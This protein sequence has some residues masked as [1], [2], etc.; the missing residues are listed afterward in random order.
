MLYVRSVVIF[1]ILSSFTFHTKAI[2][3]FT[4]TY[5]E[6]LA[7]SSK[8]KLPVL[9]YFTAKWCGPCRY[10]DK[11]IFPNDAVHQYV[12][13]NYIALS[14]DVD[15]SENLALYS[16][17]IQSNDVSVPI[18]LI[19]NDKE[20]V[21]KKNEG[22]MKLNELIAFLRIETINEPMYVARPDSIIQK[23]QADVRPPI[24][25]KFFYNSFHNSW[26]LG[27]RFS[28]A[29]SRLAGDDD[30]HSYRRAIVGF[31]V[32]VF[33]ERDFDRFLIQPGIAYARKGGT[34]HRSDE[35]MS[36]SYLEIPINVGIDLFS[37]SIAGTG[38]PIRLNATPYYALLLGGRVGEKGNKKNVDIGNG[39]NQVSTFDYGV[40]TGL[41]M[42]LG[43]FEPAIG[44][45][46]GFNKISKRTYNSSFYFSMS[47]VFGK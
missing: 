18:F 25:E 7:K 28:V 47:V 40:K 45:D 20:E 9:L 31:N 41:S 37:M 15:L 17:Y 19:V 4:G 22:S 35:S 14:L 26:K 8:E 33:F 34:N 29:S 10:M 6:A 11:Y 24:M 27:V 12:A 13:T 16:K 5:K 44:Y 1:I 21:L 38:R 3:F 46:W 2:D 23:E 36:L 42:G 43:S 30:N 32:N 39:D